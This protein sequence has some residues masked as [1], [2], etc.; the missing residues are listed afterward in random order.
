MRIILFATALLF[1]TG[2]NPKLCVLPFAC[3]RP[4]YYYSETK[5]EK[6]KQEIINEKKLNKSNA[7]EIL[8]RER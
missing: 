4:D 2:C 6:E 8:N 5:T 3:L 7:N 1:L